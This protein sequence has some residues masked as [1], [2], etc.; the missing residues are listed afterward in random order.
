M[1]YNTIEDFVEAKYPEAFASGKWGAC[2]L[3]SDTLFNLKITEPTGEL[4]KTMNGEYWFW[5]TT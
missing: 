2:H 4:V 3:D 1:E 5:L